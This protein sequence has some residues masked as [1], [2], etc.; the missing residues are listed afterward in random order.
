MQTRAAACVIARTKL[1]ALSEP[2]VYCTLLREVNEEDNKEQP[3]FA[4][5]F[6]TVLRMPRLPG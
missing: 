4:K 3:N 1:L 2:D 5:I 6:K